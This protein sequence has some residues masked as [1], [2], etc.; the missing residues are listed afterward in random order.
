M[1]WVVVG[2]TSPVTHL[3]RSRLIYRPCKDA[4]L[5]CSGWNTTA[6]S[7]RRSLLSSSLCSKRTSLFTKFYLLYSVGY[8]FAYFGCTVHGHFG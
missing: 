7:F 4:R 6:L 5:S 8:N 3:H 2:H 1:W